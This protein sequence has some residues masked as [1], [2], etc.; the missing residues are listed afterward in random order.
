MATTNLQSMMINKGIFTCV[1][2]FFLFTSLFAQLGN[3][4]IQYFDHAQSL[5]EQGY[6]DSSNYYFEIAAQL[7][8]KKNNK[9]GQLEATILQAYNYSLLGNTSKAETI[10]GESLK[11]AKQI[12]SG[13][14][15]QLALAYH[16][17]GVANYVSGDYVQAI[18]YTQKGLDLR[19]ELY[20]GV[21]ED[22][23]KSLNNL[24][25]LSDMIGDFDK[26]L[27]YYLEALKVQ[28]QL[29]GE[30]HIEVANSLNNL[31][32]NAYSNG[33]YTKALDY[34]KQSLAMYLKLVGEEYKDVASIY[35]N[36]GVIYKEIGA[37]EEALD[38]TLKA[39][40][41]FEKLMGPDNPYY[42]NIALNFGAIYKEI[43]QLDKALKYSLQ[44]FELAKQ[45]Y[46]DEH[47]YIASLAQNI[48]I[49]YDDLHQLNRA[50]EWQ[51]ISLTINMKTLGEE[52]LPVAL[53]YNNLGTVHFDMGDLDKAES[54][55]IQS[56]DI[57]KNV[58]GEPHIVLSRTY[59]NLANLYIQRNELDLALEYAHKGL[60]SVQPNFKDGTF[61]SIP[62]LSNH[63]DYAVFIE[64]LKIKAN[65][66]Y[67]KYIDSKDLT[68]LEVATK[69]VMAAQKL[70]TTTQNSLSAESD[71]IILTAL[72]SETASLAIE[73]FIEY[74]KVTHNLDHLDNAFDV[75]EK[76]KAA[77]LNAAIS[78]SKA[79]NFA[80]IP[81]NLLNTENQ[82]GTELSNHRQELLMML[83]SGMTD[84]D[85]EIV[86][87]RNEI[88]D[89]KKQ[90]EILIQQ[91]EED[92]PKYHELKYNFEIVTRKQI[93]KEYLKDKPNTAIVEFIGSQSSDSIL[94]VMII[95]KDA[96]NVI[97]YNAGNYPRNIKGLRNAITFKIDN[98]IAPLANSL[99]NSIWTPIEQIINLN[100]S[101][102]KNV[103][104]VPDGILGY[105]PFEML[106]SKVD[107]KL[108]NF[109]KHE[110]LLNKYIIRYSMS[111]TLA[112]K[113]FKN[114]I[115]YGE[116]DYVAFAPVFTDESQTN[117]LVHSS[118]RFYNSNLANERSF[119]RGG[120]INPIP[121]TEEEVV[122]IEGLYKGKHLFSKYFLF[123]DAKEENIKSKEL[124]GYKIIHMATHGFVN[125]AT[126]ELSGIV[127]SQ[128]SLS[129][130]DGILYVGEIYNLKWNADLVTLSACE[131]GLGK[132]VRGEG[133]IGLTRAFLYAGAENVLVSL[134]KVSDSST[135]Q[136]MIDFYNNLLS[137][138]TKSESLRT[139][140]IH[141]IKNKEFAHP[142]YW[143]PFILVGE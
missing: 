50:V 62:E 94:S 76:S 142:F 19:M 126:P 52:S 11:K 121:A 77:V 90:H 22:V 89:L 81:T 53:N 117:F 45:L 32:T 40:Y 5:K 140:K 103:M 113:S 110:Y 12:N 4:P 119:V 79:K 112:F 99:Y 118:S 30:E 17:Y 122:Q 134:W 63:S 137:K 78:E 6:Y 10:L 39:E 27:E 16:I 20:K 87:L 44:G 29:Y 106:I 14:N 60:M 75:V 36:M 132:V 51:N 13:K 15:L 70:I 130:E 95:T 102:I 42:V 41:L 127:L 131:T 28:K 31:G 123:K 96:Y 35:I 25:I 111:S 107:K 109:N 114:P 115:K 54:Y 108:S 135:S 21:H 120:Y 133:I 85:E 74:Y 138:E 49:I 1:L 48:G 59:L 55:L 128:D 43:N 3:D 65:I 93:Q 98:E 82:L 23:A 66:F 67:L 105:L 58:V 61:T 83:N 124:S 34:Y 104:I 141:Q 91:L 7:Y 46:G 33:N 2:V 136:L 92:Y 86:S 47:P 100:P 71:K 37:N 139:A 125:D 18:E 57:K 24:G 101:Q 88:F 8:K 129:Q 38:F 72:Q 84:Q 9:I 26:S 73:I 80:G 69:H 116:K 68:L 143:A 97:Q 56:L 64:L